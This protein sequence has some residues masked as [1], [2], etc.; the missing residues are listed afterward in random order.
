M[1]FGRFVSEAPTLAKECEEYGEH[2]IRKGLLENV[3]L[4]D[5]KARHLKSSTL[6]S[7]VE[8]IS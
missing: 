8:R 2:L 7:Y 4:P 1:K 6:S 3:G 5:L